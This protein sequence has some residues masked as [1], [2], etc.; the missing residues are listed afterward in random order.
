LT[1][2]SGQNGL[3]PVAGLVPDSK[4]ALL[5]TTASGGP[6][7]KGVVFKVTMDGTVTTAAN[8]N[9]TNGADPY[10]PPTF[11]N[12]GSMYGSSEQGGDEDAGAVFKVTPDGVLTA[13]ASFS[14]SYSYGFYEGPGPNG[15]MVQA[16]DGN[17]YGT[18]RGT[19]FRVATNGALTTVR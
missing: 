5:G 17:F 13:I 2:F 15:G 8:F 1:E 19:V 3:T 16:G 18:T 9:G 12:D 14:G 4:G 11:G 7:N 10:G 6:T